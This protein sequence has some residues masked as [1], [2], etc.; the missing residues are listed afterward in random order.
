MTT[1]IFF[2][3]LSSVATVTAERRSDAGANRKD[4]SSKGSKDE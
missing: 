3:K 2:M 4:Q 1:K